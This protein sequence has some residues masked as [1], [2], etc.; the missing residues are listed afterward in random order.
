VILFVYT[1]LEYLEW[2]VVYILNINEFYIYFAATPRTQQS[3]AA[4]M[5]TCTTS[6]CVNQGMYNSEMV[7][8]LYQVN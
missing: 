5:V 1:P 8:I 2:F 3:V 6:R 7:I 4:C